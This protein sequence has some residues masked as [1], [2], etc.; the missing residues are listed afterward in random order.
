MINMLRSSLA[1]FML[2]MGLSLF[3]APQPALAQCD[4]DRNFFSLPSWDTYITKDPAQGCTIVNFD[5]PMDI[6]LIAL[7]LLDILFTLA[8]YV[9]GG[10]II[11]GGYMM[12]SSQGQP[13]KLSQARSTIT[14]AVIGLLLTVLATSIISYVAGRIT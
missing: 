11:Y 2:A 13:D 9:A 14:N 5:F 1:I 3:A 4:A 7:A 12:M 8:F 10:F 6:W